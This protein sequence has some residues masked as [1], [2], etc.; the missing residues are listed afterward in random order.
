MRKIL[1]TVALSGLL[2]GA[3]A[4]SVFAAPLPDN[5]DRDQG[6]V[7]CETFDGPGNNQAGVGTTTTEETQGNTKNKSPEEQQDLEDT[8]TYNPPK[9][10]GAPNNC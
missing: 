8:C 5:C 6:T 9:S 2:L 7:T 10:K 4:T 3:S 1:S